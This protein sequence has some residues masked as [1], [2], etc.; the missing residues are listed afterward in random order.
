MSSARAQQTNG[1]AE[2][3]IAVVEECL[4]SRVNYAQDNWVELANSVMITL[5]S[6]PKA[7]LLG[8]SSLYYERGVQ[9]LLPID[10]VL[11]LQSP[12]IREIDMAP[13]E[14]L[15][16]VK[17][18]H[19]LHAVVRDAVS[20]AELKITMYANQRRRDAENFTVG[21]L[22]WL[23]L[24]CIEL[25][26]FRNR[27]CKKLNPLWY[28]P[29]RITGRPSPISC[30]LD[31]QDDCYIHNVFPLSKLKLASDEQFSKLRPTPLPPGEEEEGEY[32]LEKILD[33]DIKR[34][35]YYCK[36]KGYDEIYRSTWEPRAHLAEGKTPA[37]TKLL[38]DYEKRHRLDA[39]SSGGEA[40]SVVSRP[41]DQSKNRNKRQK[42]K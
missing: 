8:K 22:V 16:R 42:R 17:F 1:L 29:Y 19:D 40:K 14:V 24:T 39:S 37:Q 15:E 30:E 4:R 13:V 3:T 36:W 21:T 20:D 9:P 2:R 10:T 18:L 28:G 11:A 7:K 12:S 35:M 33:H 6:A 31:L 27:P 26:K 41:L 38:D 34:N 25:N 32:E 23:S 5:N